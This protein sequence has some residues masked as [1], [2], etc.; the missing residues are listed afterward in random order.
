MSKEVY[1]KSRWSLDLYTFIRYSWVHTPPF[2]LSS[3]KRKRGSK[4][5]LRLHKGWGSMLKDNE[6]NSPTGWSLLFLSDWPQST[7]NNYAQF[8]SC[9]GPQHTISWL[10]HL[11]QNESKAAAPFWMCSHHSIIHDWSHFKGK[12]VI[13]RKIRHEFTFL[14]LLFKFSYW[15][16]TDILCKSSKM[17]IISVDL[18]EDQ[19]SLIKTNGP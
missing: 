16:L 10:L 12:G 9:R 11:L 4:D 14:N 18:N 8:S 19:W 6:W 2:R 7:A 1:F 3:R 13:S 5:Q 15:I 17:S